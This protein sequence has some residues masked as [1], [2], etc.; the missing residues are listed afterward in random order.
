MKETKRDRYK[1]DGDESKDK[2]DYTLTNTRDKF[3]M[4]HSIKL[5]SNRIESQGNTISNVELLKAQQLS[6]NYL[7]L[8]T[9]IPTESNELKERE[10]G[11]EKRRRIE[12]KMTVQSHRL[13]YLTP[14]LKFNYLQLSQHQT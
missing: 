6:E 5:K 14:I 4:K 8:Q 2:N 13:I 12:S 1:K 10:N 3:K 9:T 11:N 7:L